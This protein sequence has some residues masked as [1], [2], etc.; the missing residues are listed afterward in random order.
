MLRYIENIEISVRYDDIEIFD[1]GYNWVST[2]W[3]SC[4][5]F[6]CGVKKT[7]NFKWNVH[8]NFHWI[9]HRF[10]RQSANSW[11]FPLLPRVDHG[12]IF[13]KLRIDEHIN[14]EKYPT[15]DQSPPLLQILSRTDP[16]PSIGLQ[17]L[18]L[19]RSTVFCFLFFFLIFSCSS[20]HVLD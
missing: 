16:V 7:W 3:S 12:S 17:S 2:F 19:D 18:T 14:L 9:F 1:I 13:I 5:M 11:N 6:T 10:F 8:W 4:K 20:V 15:I